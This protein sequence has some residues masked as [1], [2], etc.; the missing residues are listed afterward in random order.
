MF[1]CSVQ[2]NDAIKHEAYGQLAPKL[3]VQMEEKQPN[4]Q[5]CT[6][7]QTTRK[8]KKKKRKRH[9]SDSDDNVMDFQVEEVIQPNA[10]Q[11]VAEQLEQCL[12]DAEF[13]QE[14]PHAEG[15][16]MKK[17]GLMAVPVDQQHQCLGVTN[18][19]VEI[20]DNVG[21]NTMVKTK[22]KRRRRHKPRKS[23]MDAPTDLNPV[24]DTK[25]NLPA[26]P[27]MIRRPVK[28]FPAE[29]GHVH[30]D[31]DKSEDEARLVSD[32][33]STDSHGIVDNK[34]AVA[35]M[36]V[37]HADTESSQM[38]APFTCAPQRSDSQRNGAVSVREGGQHSNGDGNVKVFYRQKQSSEA[39]TATTQKLE[40]LPVR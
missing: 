23:P 36:D 26:P 10:I 24:C 33:F 17:N 21:D 20:N 28:L 5:S 30:F 22:K 2:N 38:L 25:Q 37:Q 31:S 34:K 18:G 29:K 7:E 35:A 12:V 15:P 8:K 14:N 16:V 13:K 11:T 19:N 40:S 39:L 3:R 9:H 27:A 6:D 1:V 4:S 32:A